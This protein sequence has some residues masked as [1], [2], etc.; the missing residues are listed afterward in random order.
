M[1][2]LYR[3]GRKYKVQLDAFFLPPTHVSYGQTGTAQRTD[4][5]ADQRADQRTYQRTEHRAEKRTGHSLQANVQGN[6][7][8]NAQVEVQSR[9]PYLGG[10]PGWR[11]VD[12]DRL[13]ERRGQIRR[14]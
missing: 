1:L 7:Q 13:A 3:S 14:P 6:V 2:L 8:S 5:S 11:A 9:R 10:S 12:S 4:R